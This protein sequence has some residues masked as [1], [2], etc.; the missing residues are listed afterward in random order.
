MTGAAWALAAGLGFGVFQ[1]INRRAVTDMDVFVA[2]FIQVLVSALV[3]IAVSLATVDISLLAT[4]PAGA[5][6]NFALAG[7]FH[8]TIGWTFLNASQKR[9]GAARTGALV[10][11]TPFFGALLALFTLSETL[12]LPVLLGIVVIVAGV[13]VTSN[14]FGRK[15][16]G[17]GSQPR[18]D[19]LRTLVIALGAPLCWSISPIFIRYGLAGLNSPLLGVT[20]G[21]TASALGYGVALLVRS[22]RVSSG[23]IAREALILKVAAGALVGL[24]TWGRWVALDLTAVATVLALSLISVPTVNLLTPLVVDHQ[25]ER[26]TREVWIGSVLI[27]V[28]VLFLVLMK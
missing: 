19:R 27:V 12:S 22:R 26:V 7:L 1:T 9:I 2:T 23:S 25:L 18:N 14:P 5:L 11:T 6:I 4:A 3:L 15:K 28:G 13:Y 16:N 24:S 10:G 8:F 17:N 20:V 21:I